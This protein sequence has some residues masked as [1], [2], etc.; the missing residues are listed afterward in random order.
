MVFAGFTPLSLVDFP[1]QAAAVIF[2]QG[3]NLRCPFCHN[4]GLIA[5]HET[6]APIISWH[7][8]RTRLEFRQ[9]LVAAVVISG[10][11]PTLHKGLLGI[12]GELRSLGFRIKLDS[13]GTFPERLTEIIVH[14]LVDFVALDVKAPFDSRMDAAVGRSYVFPMIE[15]S[16]RLLQSHEIPFEVRTT[17]HNG[18]DE[19]AL[20]DIARSLPPNVHWVLQHCRSL[21]NYH[22]QNRSAL[23]AREQL[24]Q[25]R[26]IV[27]D[28][29]LRG[30]N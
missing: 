11:E 30:W 27:A 15:Q 8:I 7:S 5:G 22:A 24:I 26:R 12:L 14:H 18:I 4:P 28:T 2:T 19:K 16:L 1:G 3:C 21:E 20:Q 6:S 9:D 17:C 29:Q 25:L 10:G 23:W 13:N